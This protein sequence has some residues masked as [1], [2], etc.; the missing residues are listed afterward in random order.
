MLVIAEAALDK[1]FLAAG[2]EARADVPNLGCVGL[3]LCAQC[4]EPRHLAKRF[5]IAARVLRELRET[6][7]S[8][9]TERLLTNGDHLE[10][11]L[12]LGEDFPLERAHLLVGVLHFA[13]QRDEPQASAL[14]VADVHRRVDGVLACNA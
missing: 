8:A 3:L 5:I 6:N 12:Q 7:E 1:V 13:I 9:V 10:T 2:T 4:P 11:A 14:P